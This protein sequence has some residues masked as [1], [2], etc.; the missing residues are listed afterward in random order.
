MGSGQ[1]CR[2]DGIQSL[3]LGLKANVDKWMDGW[4]FTLVHGCAPL[5]G[6][7]ANVDKSYGKFAG[8]EN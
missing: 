4:M 7:K 2:S 5:L 8:L 3:L 1:L 6:L